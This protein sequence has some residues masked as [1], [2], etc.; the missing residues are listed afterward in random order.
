MKDNDVLQRTGWLS[1]RNK[2]SGDVAIRR[3]WEEIAEKLIEMALIGN[4]A[5]IK[6]YVDC[7]WGKDQ[8][9]EIARWSEKTLG[10]LIAENDEENV[11]PSHILQEI[12]GR[13]AEERKAAEENRAP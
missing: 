9:S 7:A 1:P 5:A 12:E 3:A 10:E 11:L 2:I 13:E 4:I 8:Q 6:L